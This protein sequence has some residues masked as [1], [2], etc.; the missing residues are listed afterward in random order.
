VNRERH[1]ERDRDRETERDIEIIDGFLYLFFEEM[2]DELL[3]LFLR[4]HA[5]ALSVEEKVLAFLF[6]F[7]FTHVRHGYSMRNSCDIFQRRVSL[8]II[9]R[10]S[11]SQLQDSGT[12]VECR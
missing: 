10:F 9:T 4:I 2:R 11:S 7:L 8:T 1:R 12:N 5:C 6:N 3:H